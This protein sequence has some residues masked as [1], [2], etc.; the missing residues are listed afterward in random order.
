MS[1]QV[2]HSVVPKNV[3]DFIDKIEEAMVNSMVA[4]GKFEFQEA[5]VKHTF[6]PGMYA[7]EI[8]MKPG[9]RI[10]SKIHLTEHQ[11][12]IS[13]GSVVVY[14]GTGEMLLE[15]PYHGITKP[16]TRRV[17]WIP[18]EFGVDVIW[19]TFHV[20]KD[21]ETTVEQIEDRILEKRINPLLNGNN[22]SSQLIENQ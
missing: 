18:E 8:T 2:T 14:D 5:E 20:L 19:T 3:N 1:H 22:I 10:T 13:Q 15:A 17:L 9:Q 12:I 6:T 16:G 21:G 4:S 11:F 7:R